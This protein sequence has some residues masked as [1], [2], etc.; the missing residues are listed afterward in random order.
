MNLTPYQYQCKPSL[1]GKR[2]KR[3]WKGEKEGKGRIE[4]SEGNRV[5]TG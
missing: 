5:K 1:E 4:L 3:G 2:T